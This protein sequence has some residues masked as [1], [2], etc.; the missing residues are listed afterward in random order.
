MY[1]QQKLLRVK[2]LIDIYTGKPC[3]NC[4]VE[5]N[6]E[7]DFSYYG[8]SDVK[9]IR[10]Y[11][12]KLNFI[13]VSLLID[14]ECDARINVLDNKEE[15]IH[16]EFFRSRQFSFDDNIYLLL[17]LKLVYTYTKNGFPTNLKKLLI[18]CY[19]EFLINVNKSVSD[20]RNAGYG[21]YISNYSLNDNISKIFEKEIFIVNSEIKEFVSESF[22]QKN[23]GKKIKI[24][25]NEQ[26]TDTFFL[27]YANIDVDHYIDWIIL[28]NFRKWYIKNVSNYKFLCV[29]CFGVKE[30]R[31]SN[32]IKDILY[33][34][35]KD[36]S[37]EDMYKEQHQKYASIKKEKDLI[38][39]NEKKEGLKKH[40]PE[41]Y[42][43]QY[44][45][46]TE[47]IV[48]DGKKTTIT[49]TKKP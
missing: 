30:R 11:Y 27:P 1:T 43:A 49:S 38:K 12:K 33:T 37:L 7:N 17:F 8:N 3:S 46:T 36:S 35:F 15:I 31:R 32:K 29:Q 23:E 16:S 4:N 25:V 24:A 14:Y 2:N 9:P 20:S 21:K 10:D 28:D 13:S 47:V 19:N 48:K 45:I 42:K 39:K 41:V 44:G 34:D 5:T 22:Y 18:E 6:H 40:R 26:S